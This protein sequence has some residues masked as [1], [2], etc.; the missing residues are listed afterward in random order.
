MRGLMHRT[1]SGE[2]TTQKS[3]L[4]HLISHLYSSATTPRMNCR[5]RILLLYIF[6]SFI[7]S[8]LRLLSRGMWLDALWLSSVECKSFRTLKIAAIIDIHT[9]QN[10]ATYV[11]CCRDCHIR[12]R[13]QCQWIN[14]PINFWIKTF[15]TRYYLQLF[16]SVIRS[17]NW[18][19]CALRC[20][21]YNHRQSI[22]SI[23][24]VAIDSHNSSGGSSSSNQQPQKQNSRNWMCK[25]KFHRLTRIAFESTIDS[26]HST[27]IWNAFVLSSSSSSKSCTSCFYVQDSVVDTKATYNRPLTLQHY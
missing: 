3:L 13:W 14:E 19:E 18:I 16:H 4:R 17:T 15:S 22:F 9:P 21:A 25:Y 7:S 10:S 23:H 2:S 12:N 24:L 26:C 5:S 6:P 8:S 20:A 27:A 1:S 11:G